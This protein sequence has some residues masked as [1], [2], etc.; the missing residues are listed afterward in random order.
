VS[1]G[2]S[3]DFFCPAVCLF[4]LL[5]TAGA[6]VGHLHVLVSCAP[7]TCD[8]W[9]GRSLA[10]GSTAMVSRLWGRGNKLAADLRRATD[11]GVSEIPSELVNPIVDASVDEDNRVLI[12]KHLQECLAEQNGRYWQR[13][14]AAMVI[15]EELA[16]S[17][18]P[19]LMHESAVGRHFDVVQRLSLLEHYDRSTDRRIKNTI[20]TKA[21][22]VRLEIITA[23]LQAD[24]GPESC[25]S[26]VHGSSASTSASGTCDRSGAVKNPVVVDGLV[27]VGHR[28]DTTSESSA[29]ESAKNS[30]CREGR[31]G[32]ASASNLGRRKGSRRTATS[33]EDE[34]LDELDDLRREIERLRAE[35][36]S[37]TSGQQPVVATVLCEPVDLL[38]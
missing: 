5:S 7:A 34:T 1:A 32:Q 27:T 24:V 4:V 30:R 31:S 38:G 11:S 22:K 9:V 13:V 14:L 29:D 28:D 33:A 18:A 6:H 20:V 35:N 25:N 37:L 15:I 36:E 16:R 17:G 2:L 21:K 3:R 8:L 23:L 10:F 26:S 19:Q 12:M